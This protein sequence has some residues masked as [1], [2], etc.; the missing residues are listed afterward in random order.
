MTVY[1]ANKIVRD[2]YNLTNPTE[3]ETFVFTEA[4]RF[5]IE[6]TKNPEYMTELGGQYYG[7][8]NFDLALKY[9]E[10]AA[11]YDYLPAISGLG[12]IW[13]YGRTGEKNYEKAFNYFNR[14][15]E[16][17]DIN[18]SYKVA[19]MYKNG[20]FV[21]KDFE[22]YKSIIEKIYSHIK[23]RGDYHIPEICTRLAKIRS[24]EGETEEALALY[25]RARAHLSFRIQDNPF[26]GNLTI[27]KYLI[28]D[29]YKL[30][31]FDKSDMG[32]YDLYYVLSSPAKVTFVF[33]FEK[34]RAESEAQEDGSVAVCFDGRWF[35]TVDDFFAK[36]EIN[37]ELLTALY[38]EL[39]DFEVE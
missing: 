32:L 26:F 25:D 31:E 19:D 9:Y 34:H 13:Y 14:G 1:E 22:K 8:R 12:Y 29:T 4:L 23:Y 35:R 3:E 20:Y 24:D 16:L 15:F 7:E 30:R 11:E 10:L 38:E 39:Y 18:C 36:A 2:F 21:E 37:G 33:D 5:L 28:L 27:M 6:E 17:G